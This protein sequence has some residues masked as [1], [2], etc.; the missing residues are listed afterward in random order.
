MLEM[1]RRDQFRQDLL[2]GHCID[3]IGLE[4][5]LHEVDSL[6]AAAVSARRPAP[7]ARCSCG[8][9][10][11]WGS[12]FCANCGRPTPQAPPVVTC[13]ACGAPLPA[14]VRFCP[15]CGRSVDAPAAGVVSSLPP[16]APET[17]PGREG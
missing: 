16:P 12:H 9:P 3:L 6:L 5:R 17:S 14:D 7:A 2:V 13:T 10:L 11:H 1:Y 8:A 15:S 4:E